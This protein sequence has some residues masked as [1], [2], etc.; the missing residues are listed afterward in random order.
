MK[1]RVLVRARLRTECERPY[2]RF[3][4]LTRKKYLAEQ[5]L[6]AIFALWNGRFT[7]RDGRETS[8]LVAIG[9]TREGKGRSLESRAVDCP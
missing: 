1:V 2:R 8:R 4:L 7:R 3:L 5:R 6:C 9:E